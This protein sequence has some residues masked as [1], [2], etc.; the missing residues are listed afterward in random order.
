M[1][2]AFPDTCNTPS[3]T[4]VTPIPYPNVAQC[5]AANGATCSLK[6]K[7]MNQPVLT[8]QSVVLRTNGDEAGAAGGV[9]SGVFGD[10]MAYRAGDPRVSVEGNDIAT[11]LKPTAHNGVSAN[12]PAGAQLVPSQFTVVVG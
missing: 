6:V 3:P 11:F 5:P 9:T 2:F 1:A 10:Q 12:A 8:R 4:G 7:I